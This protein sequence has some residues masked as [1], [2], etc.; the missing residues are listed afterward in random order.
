MQN[1]G[2]LF[3]FRPACYLHNRLI[4]PFALDLDFYILAQHL[5]K[6]CILWTKKCNIRKYKT[7]CEGINEDGGRM[8]K[9]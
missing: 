9:K 6:M 1:L 2:I 8:S 7:F 4:N 3:C 5:G